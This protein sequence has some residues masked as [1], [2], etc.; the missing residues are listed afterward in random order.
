[1]KQEVF[2]LDSKWRITVKDGNRYKDGN[3]YH[4]EVSIE[5]DN[6]Y[7]EMKL[8]GQVKASGCADWGFGKEY[9][10][11]FCGPEDAKILQ[12]AY[13]L[14]RTYIEDDKDEGE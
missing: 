3:L 14:A 9:M 12:T 2:E 4:V 6:G 7:W 8:K 13:E 1:M 11:H 10:I 5:R